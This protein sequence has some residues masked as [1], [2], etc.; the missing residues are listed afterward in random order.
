MH[1]NDQW[2]NSVIE[3]MLSL[4]SA[5]ELAGGSVR[6][7]LLDRPLRD[8]ISNVAGPNGIR[9]VWEPPKDEPPKRPE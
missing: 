1:P 4:A 9:F 2:K 6:H 5:M 8:F 7:D 3:C